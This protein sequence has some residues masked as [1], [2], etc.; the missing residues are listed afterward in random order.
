VKNF[1]ALLIAVLLA[2]ASR[3]VAAQDAATSGTAGDLPPAMAMPGD[4]SNEMPLGPGS[5]EE[6]ADGGALQP[7][8]EAIAPGTTEDA[9]G[10][11]L[12]GEPSRMLAA[13]PALLESTG[14][15]LRRG[16][17]YTEV[18]Y[19]LMNR[20]WDKKG[21]I[22]AREERLVSGQTAQPIALLP[23]IVGD[24]LNLPG[25]S[26]GAEGMGRL[27]IGRFLFRDA[28]NRDH[29]LEASWVGGG[30]FQTVAAVTSPNANSTVVS[31]A[32]N[33]VALQV[34][35]FIDRTINP[36]FDGAGSMSAVYNSQI[37]TGELNYVV[38]SRLHRDRMLLEPN[39]Q[40]V[41]A[42]TPT[43][44]YG[45]L[46]GLRYLS[47]DEMLDWNATDRVS[48]PTVDEGGHYFVQTHNQLF[49]T[50]LGGSLG[51]ET[52]RWSVTGSAKAGAYLNRMHLHSA[53]DL[54][55]TTNFDGFTNSHADDIAFVSEAEL[56]AKWHLRPNV[57]LRTGLQMMFID[58]VALAPS[59]VNFV[60]GS[61]P[62]IA[63]SGDSTLLGTSF[64]IEAYW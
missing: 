55:R 42:A 40:W 52:A 41:Q 12:L 29:T 33:P 36:S 19:M 21:L 20:S 17:W 14:T 50:Q 51:Y 6:S 1:S 34:S 31:T 58:S 26:P 54:N 30:D 10:A 13:C 64:G 11:S 57:S 3:N 22:L 38:R 15:W 62:Q 25:G 56:L 46:T 63:R 44:T 4:E 2:G 5:A 43:R 7:I 24:Y 59:Q 32:G 9:F 60:P 28:A 16:Y 8:P 35:D 48:T 49:G 23:Y 53:F 37:N 27:K 39:G 47:L 61:Y 18:D 45:F